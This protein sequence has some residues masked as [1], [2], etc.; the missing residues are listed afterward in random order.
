MRFCQAISSSLCQNT[1]RPAHYCNTDAFYLRQH[2]FRLGKFVESPSSYQK[3]E[4]RNR[5]QEPRCLK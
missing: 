5:K 1:E 4:A 3:C 2:S